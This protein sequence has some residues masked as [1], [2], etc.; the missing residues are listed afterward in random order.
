MGRSY[1]G[2]ALR[3]SAGARLTTMRRARHGEGLVDEPRA[4][5]L[6]RLLHRGVGQAHHREGREPGAQV[7]LDLHRLGLQAE[8]CGADEAR[9]HATE[10][11]RPGRADGARLR[12]G[13]EQPARE[14]RTG[15]AP[16]P[17]SAP[18]MPP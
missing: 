13:C 16:A 7:D 6:A 8:D 2:P 18:K 10:A 12:A 9:D 3:R 17:A 11:G 4:H 14:R 1:W 5:P 15:A